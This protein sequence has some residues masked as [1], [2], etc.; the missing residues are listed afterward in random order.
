[1]AAY[2]VVNNEVIDEAL[3]SEFRDRVAAVM[4]AHGGK[5]L[6]RGGTLEVLEGNWCP[7][8]LVVVEFDSAD[9]AKALL[10]SAD[11]QEL[12]AIRERSAK[13]N[14]IVVEGV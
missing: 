1:M 11:F 14:V 9:A 2:L 4:E 5:Y 10:S 6:V 3:Y 13:A 7:E 8:R 12:K